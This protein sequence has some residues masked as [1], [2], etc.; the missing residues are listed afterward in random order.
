MTRI[1]PLWVLS[2]ALGM[3]ALSANG[4]SAL[5]FDSHPITP[6]VHVQTPTPK[7]NPN[8]SG[9]GGGNSLFSHAGTVR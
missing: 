5:R 4:A 8:G 2:G 7:T 9:T 1:S 3:L 6:T